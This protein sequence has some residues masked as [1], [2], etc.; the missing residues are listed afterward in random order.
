MGYFCRRQSPPT[1]R[2]AFKKSG[3]FPLIR[4]AA[5]EHQGGTGTVIW[6]N[7]TEEMSATQFANTLVTHKRTRVEN[8][9]LVE[10]TV[11][12]AG[13]N[14]NGKLIVEE[15]AVSLTNNTATI[16]GHLRT[17]VV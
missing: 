11:H 17:P 1:T 6:S 8:G 12:L 14:E 13:L 7:T 15:G 5:L 9:L 16:N 10:P 4:S 2:S 3:L